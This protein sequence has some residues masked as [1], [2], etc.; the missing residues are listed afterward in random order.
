MISIGVYRA[1]EI[2]RRL[3]AQL[4]CLQRALIEIEKNGTESEITEIGELIACFP[5]A[6]R[7]YDQIKGEFMPRIKQ[8]LANATHQFDTEDGAIEYVS[9]H[10]EQPGL[11][12]T[13]A[14]FI[15]LEI[16]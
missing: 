2:E 10:L 8:A 12:R 1:A 16:T 7:I 14:T 13:A 15:L 11:V 6:H 3:V 4:T 9:A 5:A